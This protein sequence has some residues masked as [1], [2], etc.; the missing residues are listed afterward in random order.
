MES[1]IFLLLLLLLL[2]VVGGPIALFVWIGTKASRADHNV[3]TLE[4]RV[5]RL[6]AEVRTLRD[7]LRSYESSS[8]APPS[9]AAPPP[10]LVSTP[11]APPIPVMPMPPPMGQRPPQG[12]PEAEEEETTAAPPLI[13]PPPI[14]APT[15]AWEDFHR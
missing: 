6:Q 10:K 3:R 13:A 8:T 4:A 14:K 5:D 15:S 7:V 12:V 1:G 9:I 2:V 11:V